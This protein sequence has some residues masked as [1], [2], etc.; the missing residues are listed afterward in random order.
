MKILLIIS[1]SIAAYKGLEL[2]R[3]GRERGHSFTTILTAGGAQFITPLA[4]ASL[5]GNPCYTDLFSL[6]DE[7]EMGHIRL[8]R[9]SDLVLIVPASADLLAKMAQ[10][11]CDD[12]ASTVLLATDKPVMVAPGMNHKMWE[13]PA[14]QRNLQQ[15]MQDGVQMIQPNA[16]LLACGEVGTGRMAEVETILD[17]IDAQQPTARALAGL[18]ALVTAG[19]TREAIDPVR[20]ISNH[21]SGK[22]G[23]AVAAALAQAGARVT[24]ISGPTALDCPIGVERINVQ[25]AEDMYKAAESALPADIAVCTAA[26]ADWKIDQISAQKMKKAD[27]NMPELRL[28]ENPDILHMVTHHAQRPRLVIGFAA[29]TEK[30]EAYARDKLTRKG[31][32]WLVANDVSN[33]VFGAD[34]NEITLFTQDGSE[35][36]ARMSKTAIAQMLVDKIATLFQSDAEIPEVAHG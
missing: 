25:S 20:Y 15:L 22:Q 14:T 16:G 29:E 33:E 28:I 5:S 8:S 17:V 35:A 2:I 3:R 30:L 1:G 32:D 34:S 10:G 18:R 13:H 36:F 7:T 23:Y 27:M 9:E 11:R 21:S 4:A 26:V 12:L 19:P 31:C 24:L 6:K